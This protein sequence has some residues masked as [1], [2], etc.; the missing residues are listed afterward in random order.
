MPQS[1]PSMEGGPETTLAAPSDDLAAVCEIADFAGRTSSLDELFAVALNRFLRLTGMEMGAVVLLDSA[2][3][4]DLRVQRGLPEAVRRQI[5]GA[6]P[7]PQSIPALAIEQCQLMVAHESPADPRERAGYPP[8]P[9][10]H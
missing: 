1:I 4:F 2:G 3:R 5:Q 9:G 10:C 8:R 7:P 6:V